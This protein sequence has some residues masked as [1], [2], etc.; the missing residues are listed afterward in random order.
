M[1]WLPVALVVVLAMGF[2]YTNG[3][4]DASNAIAAAETVCA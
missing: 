1:D 4:H 3:F 2:T